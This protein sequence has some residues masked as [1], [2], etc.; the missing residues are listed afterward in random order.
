MPSM[1]FCMYHNYFHFIDIESETLR[2]LIICKITQK[3]SDR[4]EI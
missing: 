2:G 1:F 3:I 4:A